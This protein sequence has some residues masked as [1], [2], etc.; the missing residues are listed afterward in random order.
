[1]ILD[2]EKFLRNK[3]QEPRQHTAE[4]LT[5]VEEVEVVRDNSLSECLL[6]WDLKG[7]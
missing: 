7:E 2:C 3:G 4:T 5:E 6:E 1:M